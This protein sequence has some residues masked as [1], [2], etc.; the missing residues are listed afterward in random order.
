MELSFEEEPV[1]TGVLREERRARRQGEGRQILHL[2]E[3]AAVVAV[4]GFNPYVEEVPD[5]RTQP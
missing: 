3:L 2:E 4:V 5:D 1:R